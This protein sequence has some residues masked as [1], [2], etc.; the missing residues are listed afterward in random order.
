MQGCQGAWIVAIRNTVNG[1]VTVANNA[2]TRVD[3][4]S[5]PNDVFD[6]TEVAANKISGNLICFGNTP[7]AQ[8]GDSG[9][10]P[11]IVSGHKIG[12]CAAPGL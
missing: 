7:P 12:E 3:A 10:A 2:A 4:D 11:N 6:S 1:S 5:G 9:G 8:I